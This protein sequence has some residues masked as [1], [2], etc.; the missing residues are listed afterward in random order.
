M[1]NTRG[2]CRAWIVCLPSFPHL[3]RQAK[4]VE[5]DL[6]LRYSAT[7]QFH[8]IFLG[9]GQVPML[10]VGGWLLRDLGCP[11][12]PTRD[13]AEHRLF[14]ASVLL[15]IRTQVEDAMLDPGSFTDDEVRDL[16]GF[17]VER[18]TGELIAVVPPDAPFWELADQSPEAQMRPKWS[19]PARMIGLAAAFA[20]DRMDVASEVS[21]MVGH[22][23][24]AFEIRAELASMH[25]DLLA[26]RVTYPIAFVA[27]RAAIP[28][29]P[30]PEPNLVLGSMVATGSLPAI[31]GEAH[32]R[33]QEGGRIASELDL[34]MMNAFLADAERVFALELAAAR[35]ERQA[36]RPLLERAEPTV[37]KAMAMAEG[38]LLSDPTFRESWE[39]HREGM[40]GSPEVASRF[41]AGLILEILFSRGHDVRQQV[42][43]FLAF[44]VANGFR[45]YDH[46][47]S[48]ADADTVGV[49]L[50]LLP[51]ST[52]PW[53][54]AAALD[55]VLAC[56]DRL[57]REL[58]AIPVW[59]TD[60]DAPGIGADAGRPPTMTLGESCGTVMAHALLGLLSTGF[61]AHRETIGIG[62]RHLMRRIGESGLGANVNYPPTFALAGF[63]RLL[64][65][66]ERADAAGDLDA[67]MRRAAADVRQPLADELAS[68]VQRPPETAQE[69]ALLTV[70]CIDGGRP[71][72]LREEWTA[73]ILRGQRSDGSW[74]GEPFAAAPNRG[75]SV[76]WYS[77]SMLTTALCYDALGRAARP[78]PSRQAAAAGSEVL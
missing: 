61:E 45:Y 5:Y 63:H 46:P 17:C 78:T 11:P 64:T 36:S 28:L 51:H 71:D 65:A 74:I 37:P 44:T 54:H 3:F 12:V 20:A 23:A 22:L 62:A 18:A 21:T 13:E 73:R 69:A 72:L 6:A 68:A 57:T 2:T 30:P 39:T 47:W 33:I 15:A 34:P 4:L 48:D 10:S 29:D 32:E 67:A 19:G 42:D 60:C 40:L 53:E 25:A 24:A 14:V 31:V 43:Q 35:G 59:I 70:A 8:D 38:C 49:F 50:R 7:G 66:L 52:R 75:R 58:D 41:P 27:E 76:S 1:T 26:G 56:L 77:S 16:A 55:A 9:S